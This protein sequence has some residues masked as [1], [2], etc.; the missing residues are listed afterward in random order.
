MV[1]ATACTGCH[2]TSTTNR[3]GAPPGVNF[4]S[5]PDI[6]LHEASIRTRALVRQTMPPVQPLGPGPLDAAQIADVQAFLDCR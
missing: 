5:P 4:D 3:N 1:I 2:S 6:D